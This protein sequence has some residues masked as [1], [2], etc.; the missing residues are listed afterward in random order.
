M[1]ADSRQLIEWA[2]AHPV[3]ELHATIFR[4]TG[5]VQD[6]LDVVFGRPVEDRGGELDT[7]LGAGPSEKR[8]EDLAEIHPAWHTKRV[9]YDVDRGPVLEVRHIL[10]RDDLGNDTLV[11]VP[12]GHLVTDLKLALSGDIDFGQLEDARGQLV[13][14]LDEVLLPLLNRLQAH[15]TGYR[16]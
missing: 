4:Q 10:Y 11:P 16:S 12:T 8:L 15:G 6:R 14:H 7:E 3:V 13:T 1:I 5:L 9:Q 2:T